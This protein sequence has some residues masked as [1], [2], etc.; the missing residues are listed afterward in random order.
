[1]LALPSCLQVVER[2]MTVG[3]A[4]GLHLIALLLPGDGDIAGIPTGIDDGAEVTCRGV[5]EVA[6]PPLVRLD[7][8][9][10]AFSKLRIDE[11][12]MFLLDVICIFY[13]VLSRN[14]IPIVTSTSSSSGSRR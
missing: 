8:A 6:S 7:C 11:F 14:S 13:L 5:V 3:G 9:V 1:L 12:T 4:I 10:P 2:D